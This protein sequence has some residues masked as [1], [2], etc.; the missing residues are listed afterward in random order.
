MGNKARYKGALRPGNRDENRNKE[1]EQVLHPR[2]SS[3]QDEHIRYK[4][5]PA[6]YDRSVATLPNHKTVDDGPVPPD[7]HT[8]P[9]SLDHE[10]KERS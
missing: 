2:D 4:S 5:P 7:P 8:S 10:Q 6:R 9:R 3:N 1:I